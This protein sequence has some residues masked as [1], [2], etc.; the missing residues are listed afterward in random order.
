MANCSLLLDPY[1]HPRSGAER[2][3]SLVPV[4]DP[5]SRPSHSVPCS[6]PLLNS[7]WPGLSHQFGGQQALLAYR[8]RPTA[9]SMCSSWSVIVPLPA[10]RC[11]N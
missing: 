8:H 4:G 9:L 5:G 6:D 7:P 10:Q 11:L 3:L 1:G 2:S